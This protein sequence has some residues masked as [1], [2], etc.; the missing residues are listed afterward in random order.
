V[1]RQLADVD[2]SGEVTRRHMYRFLEGRGVHAPEVPLPPDPVPAPE[3]ATNAA[4]T[5][6]DVVGTASADGVELR[7]WPV[8]AGRRDQARG[9]YA[10]A[11]EARLHHWSGSA[12]VVARTAADAEQPAQDWLSR[13]AE[14]WAAAGVLAAALDQYRCLVRLRGG[15]LLE[16]AT[17]EAWGERRHE[18]DPLL[19]GSALQV[20]LS[21][22]PGGRARTLEELGKE[23]AQRGLTVRTG[24]RETRVAFS[25]QP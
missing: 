1:D 10:V 3:P 17:E 13:A 18:L 19:L 24:R 7:R 6:Y 5:T 2:T 11:A 8:V 4:P 20:W 25:L 22:A 9:F 21:E 15:L 23:L 16:A 12:E 14:A